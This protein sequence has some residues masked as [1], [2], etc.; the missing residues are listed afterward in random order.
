ME[1][2]N[3]HLDGQR[4]GCWPVTL[5]DAPL[6]VNQELGEVPFDVVAEGTALAGL[7]KLVD[8]CG[9]IAVNIHLTC[10]GNSQTEE[11]KL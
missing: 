10:I 6:F 1:V 4:V 7:E 11:L 8:G 2:G 3:S 5:R 9:I